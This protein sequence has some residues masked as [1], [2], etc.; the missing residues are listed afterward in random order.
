[1]IDPHSLQKRNTNKRKNNMTYL[2]RN[3]A[4]ISQNITKFSENIANISQNITK[5]SE[6]IANLRLNQ[7]LFCYNQAKK[8]QV[9]RKGEQDRWIGKTNTTNDST[10]RQNV[11]S[12]HIELTNGQESRKRP[13]N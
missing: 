4:Y 1:M 5:F 12:G 9:D 7:Q 6:N 13:K 2:H 8:G 10:D 3:I 11:C